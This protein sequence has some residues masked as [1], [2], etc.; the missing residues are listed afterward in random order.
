VSATED[1]AGEPARQELGRPKSVEDLYDARGEEVDEL[2]PVC[3]GDIYQGLQMP[4]FEDDELVILIA[5]PCSLR[6]GAALRPRLQAS[7]VRVYEKVPLEKWPSGHGR[8][9]PLPEFQAGQH[10]AGVLTENSVV[11]SA[12]LPGASRIARLSRDGILLLQQRIIYTLAHT[13]VGLDTLA[14]YNALALDEIELLEGWNEQLC[15]ELAGAELQTA[16]AQT[17]EAFEDFML[18]GPRATLENP[19]TRG[20][21]RTV[22]LA[23]TQRRRRERD[24]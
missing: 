21:A 7:P 22:I 4:G 2:R 17:A 11:Q 16:L 3:Q 6:K 20:Q 23:E 18:T 24:G 5:H 9:L 15:G 19:A 14:E 1:P 12:D 10:H 8:V 13:V